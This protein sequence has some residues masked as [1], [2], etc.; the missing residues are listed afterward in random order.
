MGY[1]ARLTRELD[2]NIIISEQPLDDDKISSVKFLSGT[3]IVEIYEKNENS[4]DKTQPV[5]SLPG[6]K[7]FYVGKYYSY[8][9]FKE[10]YPQL[11]NAWGPDIK[12]WD[13][14]CQTLSKGKLH[15]IPDRENY[16]IIGL[17]QIRSGQYKHSHG[18]KTYFIKFYKKKYD[19]TMTWTDRLD[20]LDLGDIKF[21]DEVFK[22]KIYVKQRAV[23]FSSAL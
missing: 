19:K 20:S 6:Y 5:S 21:E 8:D 17:D 2:K 9:K 11:I 1:F 12:N 3:D 16:P 22:F 4:Q 10:K 15:S 14:I 7:K 18:D 13:G 23:I